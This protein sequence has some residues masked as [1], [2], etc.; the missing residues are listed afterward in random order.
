LIRH[1][2]PEVAPGDFGARGNT[3]RRFVFGSEDSGVFTGSDG[4]RTTP[5]TERGRINGVH[6]TINNSRPCTR[7]E[8]TDQSFRPEADRSPR[9]KIIAY[10][11]RDRD[12][13]THQ[14]AT[15]QSTIADCQG[16]NMPIQSILPCWMYSASENGEGQVVTEVITFPS[17]T[18]FAQVSLT[19]IINMIGGTINAQ[20]RSYTK[21]D[22]TVVDLSTNAANNMFTD[23]EVV[24]VTFQLNVNTQNLTQVFA[25]GVVF[26]YG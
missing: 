20:I 5:P 8:G 19:T 23:S 26:L 17:S 22:G 9:D 6:G 10:A 2:E 3:K 1:G 13:P 25:N 15:H 4:I 11:R 16:E 24:S 21:A 7:G 18:V 14:L 12:N